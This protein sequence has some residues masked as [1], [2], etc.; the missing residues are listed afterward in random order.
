MERP[1]CRRALLVPL[2]VAFAFL[3]T[4]AAPRTSEQEYRA[5]QAVVDRGDWKAAKKAVELAIQVA[6]DTEAGPPC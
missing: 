3:A 2:L 6:K 4:A 5:A 1:A